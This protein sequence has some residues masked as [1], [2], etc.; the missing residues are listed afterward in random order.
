LIR[1]EPFESCRS[2]KGSPGRIARKCLAAVGLWLRT[3]RERRVVLL[4]ELRL[5]W[6][7]R[8]PRVFWRND[9]I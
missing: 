1:R 3:R 9:W 7:G 8:A 2:G 4:G 5:G 6:V